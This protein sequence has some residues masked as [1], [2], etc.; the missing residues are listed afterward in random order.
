MTKGYVCI[1]TRNVY[2]GYSNTIDSYGFYERFLKKSNIG[3]N[4]SNNN[5][6]II[7]DINDIKQ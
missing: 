1:G 2:K 3:L 7:N 4:V 6:E 5:N